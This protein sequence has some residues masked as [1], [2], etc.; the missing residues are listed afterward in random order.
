MT[1]GRPRPAFRYLAQA[2]H[3]GKIV[4]TIPAGPGRA[5]TVLVTGGTGALGALAARHL[6]RPG[7]A[8][9]LASRSGP[10]APGAAALAAELAAAGAAGAGDGV[11]CRAT[12]PRWPR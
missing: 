10:A 3:A 7:R 4:L 11:R 1:S 9:V 5:G 12:G 8:L 6:A 2:R